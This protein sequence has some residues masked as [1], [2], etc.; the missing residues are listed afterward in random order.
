MATQNCIREILQN[1]AKIEMKKQKAGVF[2]TYSFD[3]LEDRGVVNKF[4]IAEFDFF[5]SVKRDLLLER[6]RRKV[7]L[8]L[9]VG[10]VD[11]E[12]LEAVCLRGFR[13][14]CDD[15]CPSYWLGIY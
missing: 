3:K 9:L 5:R 15:L 4:D 2:S 11:A 13:V 6:E 14:P 12:L 8:E 10:E 1:T 7:L